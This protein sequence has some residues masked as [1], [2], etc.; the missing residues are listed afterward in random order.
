MDELNQVLAPVLMTTIYHPSAGLEEE[1]LKIWNNRIAKL[2]YSMN[3]DDAH[4]YHNETTD[5]FLASIHWPSKHHA[6][7]FL[8]SIDFKEGTREL[9][10]FALIPSAKEHFEILIERAA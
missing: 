4:I 7:T 1:F 2:A 6:A 9:N 10:V 5:E 3:A 8:D